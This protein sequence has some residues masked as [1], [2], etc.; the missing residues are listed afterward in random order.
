MRFY[1]ATSFLFPR[2][3][4]ARMFT[5]CFG[6]VHV[7]L[8][9]FLIF[10]AIR[11]EWQ[12]SIF[13]VLLVA[14]VIGSALGILGIWG[15]LSPVGEATRSLRALRDGDL[16]RPVPVGGRDMAGELLESVA[17]AVRSTAK[18]LNALEGL[19]TTDS[20]TGLANR[21]GF[22]EALEKRSEVQGALAILDGDNFKRV[23]DVHGHLQGDRVLRA[24][25]QRLATSMSG[26]ELVARWGGD[27]F[28]IFFPGCTVEE[29][30][31]LLDRLRY[32][33]R[34]RPLADV[35][36]ERVS[37]SFG[38]TMVDADDAGQFEAVIKRADEALY[39]EKRLRAE[40]E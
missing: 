30:A 7:P 16:D 36:G 37:F 13:L 33:M 26:G 18:R 1:K 28:V 12:W 31:Y 19:A 2:S 14:T 40:A 4:A 24:M 15:L 27:E 21:R 10:A 35:E 3:Y 20:L 39:R 6:S 25:A 29:A 23:N 5:L 34:W 9:A 11:G 38:L 8:A 32:S 17:H 22:L